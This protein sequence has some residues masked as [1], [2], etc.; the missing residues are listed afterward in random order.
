VPATTLL[1]IPPEEQVQ[2][3]AVLRRPRYGSLRAF[4]ILWLGAVGR[5]PTEIAAFLL[6]S[7]SSVSRMVRA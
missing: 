5:P 7:R 1:E 4:H 6:C 3:R 2:M